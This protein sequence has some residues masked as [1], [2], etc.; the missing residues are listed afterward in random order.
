MCR[1]CCLSVDRQPRYPSTDADQLALLRWRQ[2][3]HM[4]HERLDS[5]PTAAPLA[6]PAPRRVIST[7][8]IGSIAQRR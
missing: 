7:K 6:V 4:L 5:R 2:R 8:L 3:V 1:P